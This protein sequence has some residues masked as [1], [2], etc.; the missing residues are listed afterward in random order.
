[1]QVL[2][3]QC[4]RPFP[5]EGRLLPKAGRSVLMVTRRD[6]L[7]GSQIADFSLKVILV[8]DSVLKEEGKRPVLN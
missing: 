4:S 7:N 1:M 6:A 2:G 5:A 8:R 3:G